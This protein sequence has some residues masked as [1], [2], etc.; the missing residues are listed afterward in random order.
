MCK[1]ACDSSGAETLL[2]EKILNALSTMDVFN[3]HPTV[4]SS[5]AGLVI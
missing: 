4:S 3:N 1:I 2:D 5:D